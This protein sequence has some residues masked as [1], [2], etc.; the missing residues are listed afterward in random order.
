MNNIVRSKGKT[1]GRCEGYIIDHVVPLKHGGADSLSN[2]QWLT[3]E[4]N[5]AKDAGE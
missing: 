4:E 5:K 1:K 2:M 3:I